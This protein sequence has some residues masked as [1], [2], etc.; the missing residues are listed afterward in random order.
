VDKIS[1][2][3][4][5]SSHLELLH[6]IAQSGAW[7]KQGLE[8]EYDKK[9]GSGRAHEAIMSGDV[10]FVSGNHVSPYGHRARGDKWVYL[11]QTV[12]RCAGRKLVVHADSNIHSIADLREKKVGSRGSHPQLNDWLQLKQNG[13]DVDRDEVEIVGQYGGRS[14]DKMEV[15]SYKLDEEPQPLW[16]LVSE[17]K[18]D[19]AFMQGPRALFAADD[20]TLRVIDLPDFP[21]IYFCTIS[22]NSSFLEKHP[23]IVDRFLRG[24]IEGIHFYKT[25]PEKTIAILK[26]QFTKSGQLDLAK[27]QASQRILADVLEPKMYP[28]L[29]AIENVYTEGVRFDEDAKRVSPMALWDLHAIRKIDDSGFIDDLYA[30]DGKV[31][32]PVG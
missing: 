21:M 17:K 7:E 11:A 14:K 12:N 3:Y 24:M 1:F 26:G 19:A 23:D 13:L 27:A 15:T 16:E 18:V 8:V 6:V 9:I 2:P 5:S 31:A 28:S 10:Q 4:R 32:E 25:Q 20:P 22:T 29:A 30:K